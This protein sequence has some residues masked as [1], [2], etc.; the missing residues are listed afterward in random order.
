MNKTT[1]TMIDNRK[2]AS[3]I[4]IGILCSENRRKKSLCPD[5]SWVKRKARSHKRSGCEII[6]GDCHWAVQLKLKTKNY[7]NSLLDWTIMT[8]ALVF[9][10]LVFHFDTWNNFF[11]LNT[12]K[13]ARLI[14]YVKNLTLRDNN[15]TKTE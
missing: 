2:G 1:Q 4:C 3:T 11:W 6:D 13:T 7:E 12:S 14:Y 10:F 9:G 5:L 8:Y 15:T